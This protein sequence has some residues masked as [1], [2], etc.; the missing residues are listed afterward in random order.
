MDWACK[1]HH[2]LTKPGSPVGWADS[3]TICPRGTRLASSPMVGKQKDACPPYASH[4]KARRTEPSGLLVS[5]EPQVSFWLVPK[6]LLLGARQ[7]GACRPKVPKQEFGNQRRRT[8]SGLAFCLPKPGRVG[9]QL[10]R[11][12]T[13]NETRTLPNN[14][15]Q[16]KRRLPT[17]RKPVIS[18]L[19]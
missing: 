17:L 12:P 18:R 6:L 5:H 11:L 15:G 1:A 10:H 4:N 3:F 13:R 14:G 8:G 16:A 2:S 19:C 7:A 9:R